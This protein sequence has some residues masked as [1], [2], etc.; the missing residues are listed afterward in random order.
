MASQILSSDELIVWRFF[1][2]YKLI[3]TVYF[4]RCLPLLLVLQISPLNICFSIPSALFVCP[5]NCIC[6]FLMVLSW[7]LFY[8]DISI[9]SSFDFFSVRDILILLLVYLP[10][11]C[12]HIILM[13]TI[14]V[15]LISR[16]ELLFDYNTFLNMRTKVLFNPYLK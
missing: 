4:V 10:Y 13:I 2:G 15:K 3:Q 7:D 16:K 11:F 6:L 8:P 12:C 1:S 14:K 5:K 9:T